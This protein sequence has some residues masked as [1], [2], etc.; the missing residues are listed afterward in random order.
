MRIILSIIITLIGRYYAED[1]CDMMGSAKEVVSLGIE[2][3][4]VSVSVSIVFIRVV[5]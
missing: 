4:N 2:Y 3:T 1:I 5:A